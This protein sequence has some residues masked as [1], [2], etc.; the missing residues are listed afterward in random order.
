MRNPFVAI[1]V[2]VTL[3]LAVAPSVSWAQYYGYPYYYYPNTPPPAPAYQQN[4]VPGNPFLYRLA[5]NPRVF[6]QWNDQIRIWDFQEYQRSPLN[7]ESPLDYMLR[8]F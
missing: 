2:A 6:R 5:P 7:P 8:T 1:A 3:V 4:Q